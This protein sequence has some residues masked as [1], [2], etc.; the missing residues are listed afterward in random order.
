MENKKFNV[1]F[2]DYDGVVNNIIWDVNNLDNGARYSWP[3]DNKVNDVQA[4]LWI[5]ALC[6]QY[7]FKIVVS[8][9]WRVHDNYIECLYNGGLP[10]D[11]EVIGRTGNKQTRGL[12]IADWISQ[13]SDQVDNFII[14]DDDE[15]DFNN[16]PE[17]CGHNYKV[18]SDGFYYTAFEDCCRL[19]MS[20]GIK[21]VFAEGKLKSDNVSTEHDIEVKE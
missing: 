14:V 19:C 13:H 7:G 15:F 1:L 5:A 9:S 10:K 21:S 12:E 8:S 16:C 20:L 2:L 11:I 17:V 3:Y 18:G 4:C 6:R